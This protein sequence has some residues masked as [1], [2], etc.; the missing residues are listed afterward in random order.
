MGFQ[1]M[2][3]LSDCGYEI[4]DALIDDLV[5]LLLLLFVDVIAILLFLPIDAVTLGLLFP[6]FREAPVCGLPDGGGFFAHFAP[7]LA[8]L[9]V[10]FSRLFNVT[11]YDVFKPFNSFVDC[12]WELLAG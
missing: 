3:K 11:G 5:A 6:Q 8:I 7:Q 9:C 10:V 12:Q 2:A 4:A 1:M